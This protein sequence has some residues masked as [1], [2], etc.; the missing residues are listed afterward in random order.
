MW[1]CDLHD[2]VLAD[3]V[4][5]HSDQRRHRPRRIAR[6]CFHERQKWRLRPAAM[7]TICGGLW[8]LALV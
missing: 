5:R 6:V 7:L 8:M 1:V 2:A 4:R 3:D